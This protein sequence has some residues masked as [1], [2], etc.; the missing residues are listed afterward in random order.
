MAQ[1]NVGINIQV[2]GNQDQA[3]GSL[4]AQLREATAEVTK[5]SEQFGASSKEAVNAA[6]RAAELKDQIGDAKSLI[7]AFNPDAKFKALTASLSGVAGGFSALQGATAL[8]GKENEDLQKTLLKVNSAMALSQGLQAVGE[9]IDSFKQLGTVIKTQVVSAFSTLRGTLIA[10]GIGALAIGIGLVAANFDKVKKA[11]LG[12]VP[13]LAQVGT[14]FSSIITKVTDFVGITSQ[15][16]RALASLE[17]T[18]KR[19]NEGIEARIKVLTAQG[20]KEKEIYQLTK[21]QGENE[22]TF[23]RAKLK[24]KEGLNE[25]ELKKFRGLKT[26]QAVLDAQEQKRQKEALKDNAKKGADASKQAAEQRKKENEEKIA[27]EKEAQQKLSDL[28]NQLFLSTFKDENEKKKAEL[29]LAFIKEKDEILANTKINES[30][31]NE[32]IIAARLKLNADLDALAVAQRE[33]KAAEDAKL[34][35]ESAKQIETENDKEYNQLQAEIAKKNKLNADARKAELDADIS[36]QNA[37]FEAASAGLNLLSSLAGQNEKIA[38]AIFV[39]DKALAIAKIVVDTQREI[40]GYYAANSIFG[41]AGIAIA[42]KQ[43]LVA[44]IR[45]GIGIASIAGTTIAKFK[46][47]GAAGGAVGGSAGGAAPS[48]SA[49]APLQP[50]QP[51]TTTL[52]NQTIN[53]IGSQTTRAYVV[54]SDVTSNQQRIAAIQQR[55]RF[56]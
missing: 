4:K 41:P 47:G 28:R 42:T 26:E 50:P 31:R 24:T 25:E 56:G 19:G 36:L 43:A 46:G 10:T 48:V 35:E 12:L 53:A 27:A 20:G 45:A 8:F 5:L 2:G 55:A 22:L 54:E 30:T 21:Q 38:N 52:S 18:T 15:A 1:E 11:V 51:Q 23:L 6:K 33:K 32:L 7:D 44:K 39:I 29:N 40:A 13:G 49:S 3:L 17:K 9:S 34:L 14:F 37:K 16:E